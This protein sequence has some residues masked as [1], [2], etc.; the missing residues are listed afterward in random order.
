M[1]S[2]L[3]DPQILLVQH[4]LTVWRPALQPSLFRSTYFQ[5]CLQAL[6]DVQAR[7]WTHDR[8]WQNMAKHIQEHIFLHSANHHLRLKLTDF[9]LHQP[10]YDWKWI[11]QQC[12]G[13]V[14]VMH[15]PDMKDNDTICATQWPKK[16]DQEIIILNDGT[17]WRWL[18]PWW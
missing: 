16:I 14:A 18:S 7:A 5:M 1:L 4:L 3:C 13:I 15:E 12:R 11:A 6:V 2:R 17:C 10:E 9:W 8:L